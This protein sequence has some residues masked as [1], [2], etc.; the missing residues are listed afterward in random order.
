MK[1]FTTI[2]LLAATADARRRKKKNQ[3]VVEESSGEGSGVAPVTAEEAKAAVDTFVGEI[4]AAASSSGES[5]KAM[6][7][8]MQEL[9]DLGLFSSA[10]PACSAPYDSDNFGGDDFA[11]WADSAANTGDRCDDSQSLQT[12]VDLYLK[13]F[14]CND[15]VDTRTA[16]RWGK[17]AAKLSKPSWCA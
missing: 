11:L 15:A 6:T 9:A 10:D 3:A 4:E 13:N 8:R 14:G 1:L 2:V 17:I 5:V 7:R 12:G 16:K